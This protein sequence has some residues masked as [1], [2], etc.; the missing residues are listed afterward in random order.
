M[1]MHTKII[2]SLILGALMSLALERY[3]IE[4]LIASLS[5]LTL[6]SLCIIIAGVSK[7]VESKRW[8]SMA[9]EAEE[10]AAGFTKT[11]DSEEPTTSNY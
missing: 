9:R 3:P 4:T 8:D 11:F 5:T 7:R 2:I 6:L 10:P 1:K